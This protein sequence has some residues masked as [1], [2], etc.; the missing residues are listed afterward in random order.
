MCSCKA[1]VTLPHTLSVGI[2]CVVL[3]NSSHFVKSQDEHLVNLNVKC[4]LIISEGTVVMMKLFRGGAQV[5]G[6][7]KSFPDDSDGQLQL[8]YIF[9]KHKEAIQ[10]NILYLC[11]I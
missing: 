8:R 1:G 6:F 5:L 9:L 10:Q 3:E 7:C 11:N 2:V 4:L